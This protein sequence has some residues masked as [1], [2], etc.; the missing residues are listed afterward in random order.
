MVYIFGIGDRHKE[1]ILITEDGL[2]LDIDFGFLEGKDTICPTAYSRIPDEIIDYKSNTES[3]SKNKNESRSKTFLDWC[4][5]FYLELR[6]YAI[7]FHSLFMLLH[8]SNEDDDMTLKSY[9]NFIQDR[10]CIN[11]DELALKKLLEF[12]DN[13]RKSSLNNYIRDFTHDKQKTFINLWNNF[14]Y[15]SILKWWYNESKK[16]D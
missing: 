2:L 6:R 8:T 10:F 16:D 13:S 9:D 4:E 7:H 3:K 15:N 11:D 1:N 12:I 14:S 5:C